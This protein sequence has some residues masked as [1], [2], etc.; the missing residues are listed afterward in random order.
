MTE[1]AVNWVVLA[2]SFGAA[3]CS[4]PIYAQNRSNAHLVAWVFVQFFMS[5][6]LS[7]V[8]PPEL[9]WQSC[10]LLTSSHG[11][12]VLSWLIGSTADVVEKRR[13]IKRGEYGKPT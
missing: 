10:C 6:G 1:I 9:T 2:V 3:L 4:V 7:L 12:Y 11:T 5:I 8:I 13:F